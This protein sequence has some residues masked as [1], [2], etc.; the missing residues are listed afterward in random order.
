MAKFG[1]LL[2]DTEGNPFYVDDTMPLCLISKISRTLNVSNTLG[3]VIPVHYNDGAVR[4]IFCKG[5][6]PDVNFYYTYDASYGMYVV[7][8][9]AEGNFVVDVYVFGYQYQ[10]PP[11]WGMAIWDAQGRCIITNETKVLRGIQPQGTNGAESAGYNVDTTLVGEF[12]VAPDCLG[13]MS[14]VINQGGQVYPFVAPA[15]TSAYFNGSSTRIKGSFRGD[16]GG[17]GAS[18]IQ[19]VN[20]RNTIKAI[21]VNRY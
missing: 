13:Y 5:N 15:Y 6:R 7:N 20:H 1:A 16:T 17:G 19:Y 10:T 18:N 9:S 14:G 21:N 4:F 2:E 8:C 12:A 3:G 11:P